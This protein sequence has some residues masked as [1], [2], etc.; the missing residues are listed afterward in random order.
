MSRDIK[1]RAW[2]E[3]QK[4]MFT[5]VLIGNTTNP[6]SFDYTTHCIFRD[7]DWYHSDEHDNVSFMQ[8][9]GLKD[10]NGLDIYEGDITPYLECSRQGKVNAQVYYCTIKCQFRVKWIDDD[11]EISDS[12]DDCKDWFDVIGNIRQNPELI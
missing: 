2:C 6:D 5:K 10:K 12:L 3:D 1:F 9:T 4:R 7:G 11:I 8:F